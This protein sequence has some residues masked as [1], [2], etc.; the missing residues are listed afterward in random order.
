MTIR[1]C[2]DIRGLLCP[3]RILEAGGKNRG[4]PTTNVPLADLTSLQLGTGGCRYQSSVGENS[5]PTSCA[6]A[7]EPGAEVSEHS[8]EGNI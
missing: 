8:G 2:S 7:D 4:A 1:R 3:V 6:R 5:R